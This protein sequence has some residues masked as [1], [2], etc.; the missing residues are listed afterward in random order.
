MATRRGAVSSAR[1]S[2]NARATLAV[3]DPLLRLLHWGLVAAVLVSWLGT[4]VL[5]GAHRPAGYLALG[6]VMLRLL[7]GFVGSR[8]ARFAQFVR[9]PRATRAYLLDLLHRREARYIGHNPL[10]ACMVLALLGCVLG[11]AL[12]G[13]L[14]TSEALWGDAGVEAMHVALAWTLLGLVCLHVSGALYTGWR[15]RESLVWAMF[16]GRKRGPD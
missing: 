12:T 11:L 3:W 9:G 15:H 13:W 10:G 8:Y 14:Y 4:V 7:W 2:A 1:A 6:I 5:D 16:S